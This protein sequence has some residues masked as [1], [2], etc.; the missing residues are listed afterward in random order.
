MGVGA[1][2]L[3]SL[4]ARAQVSGAQAIP[5]AAYPTLASAFTALNAQGVGTGGVTF[6]I[7]PGYTETAANLVLTAT[8]TAASPIVFQKAA[9]AGANPTITAAAGT[10]SVLD[11][12]IGLQGSDYVTF[13]GLTLVDPAS[14][15][16]ASAQMEWGFALLKSAA[17][18]VDGCQNVV[19]RNCS[20]TLQKGTAAVGIY[21]A[22]HTPA[23]TT[24]LVPT[25]AAGTNS[26]NKFYGNTI[27]G[28]N[29]GIY[30]VGYASA[31]P[32]TYYDQNN[33]IG[34]VV[35]GTAATGNAIVNYGS[36]ATAYGIYSI[37]QNG[38]KVQGNTVNPTPAAGAALP[39]SILYGIMVATGGNADILSNT[40][41]MAS[42]SVTSNCFGIYNGSGVNGLAGAAGTV[43][44]GNNSVTMSSTTA[45]TSIFYGI[46][47]AA[48][49][50]NLNIFGN[51]LSNW[52]RTVST[53]GTNYMLYV[54]TGATAT[55]NVYNNTVSNLTTTGASSNVYC[56]YAFHNS[57]AAAQYYDNTVQNISNDGN[58]TY[59]MFLSGGAATLDVYRNRVTSLASNGLGP[60]IYGINVS[61]AVT[62][63]TNNLIGS[64][65][66]P[67]G[68]GVAAQIGLYLGDGTT[69]NAQYNS[70]YL[71]GSST[72]A[73]F[74]TSGIQFTSSATTLVTLRN[75]IV[76]NTSTAAGTGYTVALRRLGG[77][78]GTVPANL[79][80]ATNNN[81]YYA[82]TP[83]ANSLIY[84]EGGTGLSALTNPQQTLTDYKNFV[85]GRDINAVTENPPFV[86]TAGTNANF[87]KI[88]TTAPTQVEGG[89][90]P[91]SGI[92]TDYANATRS[93]TTPDIG[94]YEGNYQSVDLSG[95]AITG[96][97]LANTSS[98]AN[99]P[100]TVTITDASG[101]ATGTSAPRL[102]YR[103]G[104]TGPFV[105]VNAGSVSGSQ[106][107]FTLD[108]ALL[109]GSAAVG[110]VIQYYVAAQDLAAA[111]N[112]STSPGGG[113]GL[114]PPGTTAPATPS[115]YQIVGN[116]SGTYYVGTTA[117][118]AGTPADRVF[119]TLTAAA[120]AYN[121]NVLTGAA[122]FLLLDNA[123]GPAETFPITFNANP[124]ASATNTLRVSPAPNTNP[125]V[126]GS[127]T[128]PAVVLLNAASNIT[129]DGSNTAGGTTRNLTLTTANTG[130]SAVVWVG[131]QGI[132]AGSTN[133]ALRN[134][135]VAGGNTTS[136]FGIYAAAAPT[137]PTVT[138]SNAVSG[139][140]NDNL[141]IQNN[142]ITTAYE[143][144]YARGGSVNTAY[145]G[146]QIV[147]N[148]IGAT[149]SATG[150]VAPGNV[151]FKGIDVQ[152]AAAPLISRNFILGMDASALSL[153]NAGI[154]LNANVT[155]AVISRNFITGIH[156]LQAG[157][158]GAYG[159]NLASGTN[160]T[161]AEIS[162]NVISDVLNAAGTTN[163]AANAF[164]IRLAG[165]TGTRVYYNAVN[166][167]GTITPTTAL[168]APT[169]NT[170]A[171][172]VTSTLVTGLDV[173]NNI[174][175]NSI[176]STAVGVASYA[177]Y[178]PAASVLATSNNNDYFVSGTSGV[179]AYIGSNLFTL[180]TLQTASTKDG[181]SVSLDPLFVSGTN[182]LPAATALV[183]AGTPVSVTVDYAGTVRPATAPSIG[184]YQF[185]PQ[186]ID[187]AANALV[188]P[189]NSASST[190]FGANTP[191]TVQVRNNGTGVLDFAVNP[192]TVSVVISGPSSSTQTLTQTISTGTLAATATQNITLTSLANFAPLGLYTFAISTSVTGDVNA[193][194]DVLTPAPTLTVV[195][196]VAGTLSPASLPLCL[197]GST[198]L[199][200][201]GAA[202]GS[203]QFQQ[204]SSA[205][206]PFTDI[207][208]ATTA[209]FTTPVLTQTTYYRARVSCGSNV[210]TSNVSEITVSNPV[211]STAPTPASI[212][213]GR[214]GT[215]A[216]TAPAGV[217][218]RY[219]TAATGGTLVGT[220]SSVTTPALTASTTYYAEAFTGGTAVAGLAAYNVNDG[221][222]V[223]AVATD[224]ALGFAVTQVGTLTSVDVYPTAAG[225]LTI[226][227]YSVSGG[228]PAGIATAVPGSDVTVTVTAAQVNNRITVPLNYVLAPGEYKLSNPVGG[229]GRYTVYT[230][231]SYPM[232]S[233]NGVLTVRGSYQFPSGTFYQP[234]TYNNFFNLTFTNECASATRTPLTV[235]V[236]PGLV[237]TLPAATATSCGTT[238]YQLAGAIAGTATGATYTASGTGTFA[239]NATTLN[240]T[241]TP[242]AADV[243]AGTVTLT[244]TPTGPGAA[245]T[246]TGQLVLTLATPPNTAFSYPAGSYCAGSAA[247][248]APVLAT[249]AVTGTF[250]TTGTGLRLDPVTGVINLATQT[251]SGT[252]T[253]TNT[254]TGTGACSTTTSTATVTINP[255]IAT[256]TLTVQ[257]L[258]GGGVQLSTNPVAGVLYQFFVGGQPVG[259]ASTA[260]SLTVPNVPVS[261]SYTVVLVV[262]GG[263]SS[264]PS[265]PVLVTGTAV[266]SR[267]GVSL[268]VYPNPTTDGQLNVELAGANVNASQLTVLNALGQ[269]VHTSTA[270]PGTV[271]LKLGQLAAGVYT[272][273]V[274]TSQ[275]VL[276]QRV[277]RQ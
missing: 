194:N 64:F 76:V 183:S 143:A 113:S 66:T 177:E 52:S 141:V 198:T 134:L 249:G 210:A 271:P 23:S 61:A 11:E 34:S 201:A 242:S 47:S 137:T 235:T 264:A 162:N 3:G 236:T 102:Y 130:T 74:G 178:L 124:S 238:P 135:N 159:I 248:I 217:S 153:S 67:N 30:V 224:Y 190:C 50:A 176:S 267:N 214:T 260:F 200:L 108:Y 109:G 24:T 65:N 225:P 149:L 187:V 151:T 228:Q 4:S 119:A 259:P 21:M 262:P 166:L 250:S 36:T 18:A 230:G 2:L 16:T 256:P 240:A 49:V 266:A 60:V 232:T 192:L 136:A 239:P 54:S 112:L 168:P 186:V 78:G 71:N 122:T 199:T 89:G 86:S 106:Y 96:A 172:I 127:G 35:S 72:G 126:T 181:S 68:S 180:A 179:L 273:R 245:C 165:G 93:S 195:A 255:G 80:A 163:T 253:I 174:F 114:T 196:P 152:G 17:P 204:S 99:R 48:A 125:V 8:G 147:E 131:S 234:T 212:C 175:A 37:Y 104:A 117:P 167:F 257:A 203:I 213:A 138:P 57:A 164:G 7:A 13:D 142:A 32:Y 150:T 272:V 28:V 118:P 39:T 170:A 274:Q 100:L 91:I 33:E 223:Q 26:N 140:D 38:L 40:L 12:I 115:A 46:Q 27:G 9:G 241:Y 254:V 53:S 44:I 209:A 219:Y 56:I 269:V 92:T 123:Y 169:N 79:Q 84:A 14:N 208:G 88:S 42:G 218:V 81:L 121:L 211:I 133:I 43:N 101:V 188:S 62:N 193:A 197:S 59:G 20:I 154:E 45:T 31:S 90:Q 207:A 95:P 25:T 146:L 277:V 205:T 226:R 185:T 157:G 111:P 237:A 275:G 83:S 128:A 184:A 132:G 227:L 173:R 107:T 265:T 29:N 97:T 263:C 231:V 105:F 145:D 202:N 158:R 215:L 156:Q 268:R 206:G 129:L 216:A 258:P 10:T 222:F 1:L 191:V 15:T 63:V 98:L 270:M 75:N 243:A 148:R 41:T 139:D 247:T 6:S 73:N 77:I 87:L 161:N 55:Q 110:D 144:I 82:G 70:I 246:S 5:S 19:V 69:A 171:F 22:N 160:V 220:G 85:V 58:T 276:T 189:L 252:F 229:L 261:G 221:V 251:S 120:N 116:M 233:P 94:A 103:R 182:L 51:T 244:L 155:N